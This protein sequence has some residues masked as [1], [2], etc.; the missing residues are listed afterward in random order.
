MQIT[1]ISFNRNYHNDNF[2]CT[3]GTLFSSG[4]T[5]SFRLTDEETA[6]LVAEIEKIAERHRV[7]MANEMLS[8]TYMPAIEH[9]P[10]VEVIPAATANNSDDDDIPF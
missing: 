10:S 4:G 3:V 9:V 6:G 8:S 7:R 1:Y 5:A 2:D